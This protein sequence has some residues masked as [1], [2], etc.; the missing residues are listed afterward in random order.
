MH[1]LDYAIIG[2]S[3]AA[4]VYVGVVFQQAAGKTRGCFLAGRSHPGWLE[5][6]LFVSVNVSAMKI[7][8]V[9]YRSAYVV[10]G[11]VAA[12]NTDARRPLP[13]CCDEWSILVGG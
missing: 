11:P 5:G 7:R 10:Q 4:V 13:A 9:V 6:I 1:T 8:F 12:L 3:F 2:D